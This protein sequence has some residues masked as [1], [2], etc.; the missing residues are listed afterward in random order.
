MNA[1]LDSSWAGFGLNIDEPGSRANTLLG[2]GYQP[3]PANGTGNATSDLLDGTNGSDIG[4]VH[5]IPR[6][7]F[8]P[9]MLAFRRVIHTFDMYCLPT[10]IAVGILGNIV[11]FFVFMATY[12]RRMSSCIYLAALSVTDALFLVTTLCAWLDNINV[13]VYHRPGWCQLLTYVSF[14]TS[15]LDVW[16]VVGFTVERYLAIC[17]P[18]KRQQLCSARRA[19]IVVISLAVSGA[20]LFNFALWSSEVGFLYQRKYCAPMPK[21]YD[22]VSGLSNIDT[23]I[24]LI[25]PTV[26]IITSNIRITYAV[27]KFYRSR[28]RLEGRRQMTSTSASR[29][30]S[31]DLRQQRRVDG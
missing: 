28:V 2:F 9:R 10:V 26:I 6:D 17:F 23:L 16:Y 30:E 22:L 1:S 21:Y 11:C 14:V 24:T 7:L 31:C 25:I 13:D 3:P 20:V 12:L 4:L 8:D 18:F 5:G 15:F 29:N 27:A 19:K